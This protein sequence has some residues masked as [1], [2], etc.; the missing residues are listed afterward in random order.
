VKAEKELERLDRVFAGL[1][2]RTRRQIIHIL[3]LRGGSMTGGQIAE[4]FSCK[5][6]TISRHLAVLREA[7]LIAVTRAGRE[8][9]YTVDLEL[10]EE[11]VQS[12]FVSVRR[13]QLR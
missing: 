10:I 13:C 6:P 8:R 11:S 4:R 1:S 9:I 5:W 7:G 3:R 12:W 2:H